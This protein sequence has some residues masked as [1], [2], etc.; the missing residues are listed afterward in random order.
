MAFIGSVMAVQS[1]DHIHCCAFCHTNTET[2][3]AI[4]VVNGTDHRLVID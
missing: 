1:I 3:Y 2:L 4:G